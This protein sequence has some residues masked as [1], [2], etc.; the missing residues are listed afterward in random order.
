M[1]V[2]ALFVVGLVGGMWSVLFALL[3]YRAERLTEFDRILEDVV[4]VEVHRQYCVPLTLAKLRAWNP[5]GV[6]DLATR[7]AFLALR[8]AVQMSDTEYETF[9]ALCRQSIAC[10]RL[11]LTR[12]YIARRVEDVASQYVWRDVLVGDLI[13]FIA[14]SAGEE[15]PPTVDT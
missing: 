1:L 9:T 14:T 11:F 4:Y 8:R 12:S 15:S 10:R 5:E 13:E 7:N 2:A 3:E 6:G